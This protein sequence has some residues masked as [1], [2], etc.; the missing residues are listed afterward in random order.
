MKKNLVLLLILWFCNGLFAQTDIYEL[1]ERKDLPLSEIERRADLYFKQHGTGKGSG[2]NQYQRWLYERRFHTDENGYFIEPET[3]DRAYHTAIRDKGVRNRGVYTWKEL[4]P[5]TWQNATSSWN[6]GVGRLTSVAVNPANENIIYV[7]SPG[8]GI[9]KTTDA[10]KTWNPLIDFVNSG[11]MNVFH[12]CLDPNDAN[13]IYASLSSGGVLKSTNAG[14]TWVTTGTGPSNSRQVKV[15][16]GNS[17]LVFCAATN[18]LWRS[19]NGGAV[20]KRVET[21]TTEDIEFCPSNKAIMLSSG[22]GGGTYVRRSTDTGK[23]WVGIDNTK[24]MEKLGRTLMAV[25]AANP[26]RVYVLQAAGSVMGRFYV[27]NDTGKTYVTTIVGDAAN[28]TNYLGYSA[29]GTD[30]RGQGSYDLAI[31]ANPADADEVHIAGIICFRSLDA[32]QSFEATTV[33]T[34]PNGTG[35]NHADVHA[36]EWVNTSIYSGS[37][38]GIFRSTNNGEDWVEH[39]TGLGIRQFYRIACSPLEPKLIMGGAQDNGTTFRRS[40]GN[41]YEWLGADGMDCITSPN[42]PDVAIGTS[43][44]GSIYRTTDGG[45]SREGLTRPATGNWI[46]P[47]FMHP[48]NHDTV[49]G[50]WDGVY[51]SNDGGYSWDKVTPGIT[52]NLDVLAVAPSNTRYI[53]TSRGNTLY[54]SSDGGSTLKT[55][56]APST[57]TSIYVSKYNPLKIWITCN[58]STNRVFVSEN[59]GDTFGNISQGLPTF[60]A[61]SVVVDEDAHQTIYVGMNIGVYFRDTLTNAWTEHAV[62]LPLVSVNEVEIQKSGAKLRVGTYGRGVWESDLRNVVLPCPA[63]ATN[64]LFVDGRTHSTANVSWNAVDEAVTYTTQYKLIADTGWTT[65]SAATPN[66]RDTFRNLK[67]NSSYKWRVRSNCNMNSGNYAE[68]SFNTLVNG[69]KAIN[70][71]STALRIYPHPADGIMNVAF[72]LHQT[73]PVVI[74]MYDMAGN[75]VLGTRFN[76]NSGEN[77]TT[78]DVSL[79]PAGQYAL[80]VQGDAMHINGTC[81]LVK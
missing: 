21:S 39:S 76:A 13:T 34:Y 25:S 67:S 59:G 18:G 16:Q 42:D 35:Y 47:L 63:P 46:T 61:R 50:G 56:S 12:L 71:E 7:S 41:W 9:W 19:V 49:W 30:T 48:S 43:Q 78:L 62:G 75:A 73:G 26:A 1:M 68:G 17:S 2:N 81:V 5:K 40:D 72:L 79:L 45:Q 60:S 44:F 31:C 29:D 33:W 10:G 51:R 22:N 53:Y 77:T 15:F 6:P 69:A 66:T 36:L 55:I 27:S 74:T 65:A 57:I 20:W 8:G 38:G 24:G 37:D 14:A 70:R 11:W 3:E 28:G 32:G 64:G 23:T 4:G 80:K 52:S 58:N 54:R